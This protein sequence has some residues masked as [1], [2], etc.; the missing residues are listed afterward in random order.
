MCRTKLKTLPSFLAGLAVALSPLAS[1]QAVLN[2]GEEVVVLEEVFADDA[3]DDLA[4]I[5]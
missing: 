3:A 4:D 5:I 2:S 1:G